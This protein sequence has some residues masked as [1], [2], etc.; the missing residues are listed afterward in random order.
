MELNFNKGNGLLPAIVQDANTHKVLMLGYM[1]VEAWQKTQAEKVV[2]F[3]SRTKERLWTKGETSGNFLQVIEILVDCDQDTLLIR[4][5]PTGAVCHTGADTCFQQKNAPDFLTHL[6]GII[7]EAHET[8]REGSY[9][10]S[11]FAKGINKIAQKVGE[12]AVEVIIEA[13]DANDELFLGESAD[14]L[15]HWLVLLR[16]K[17]YALQDVVAV[18]EKRHTP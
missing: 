18:L 12:E 7:Q 9:T 11:L 14:L 16:A 15:F 6:E 17:G 4:A 8:P 10:A 3:Y 5:L 13:K 1:N 2:T